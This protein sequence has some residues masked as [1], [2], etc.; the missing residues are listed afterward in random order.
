LKNDEEARRQ[1]GLFM[2]GAIVW[3]ARQRQVGKRDRA[4]SGALGLKG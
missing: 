2:P 3:P 1:A 4:R